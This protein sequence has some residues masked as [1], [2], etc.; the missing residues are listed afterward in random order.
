[1][2]A[3][4]VRVAI[5]QLHVE[6][7]AE[8][9]NLKKIC[10]FMRRA[11]S[12]GARL[13]VFSEAMSNGYVFHDIKE[14][15]AAA[16]TIPGPFID[17][18]CALASE[19]NMWVGLGLL[20]R[21]KQGIYN[22]A[23]LIS[24][25]GK[26][27]ATYRK[28]FFIRS[29]KIW[30]RHG[31]ISFKPVTTPFGSL[32][33]IICADMR[34][35]EPA[36]CTALSGAQVL[37]NL[38]NWG[39]PDQYE[40]HTPARAIENHFWIVSADKVGSEPGIHFP[41]HSQVVN[42]EGRVVAEASGVDEEL[43][44]VDIDPSEADRV[45]NQKRFSGRRPELY[46][47]LCEPLAIPAQDKGNS[48]GVMGRYVA[49]CQ[50][51]SSRVHEALAVCEEAY[52]LDEAELM[53]LP[54]LFTVTD[55]GDEN[56]IRQ[57]SIEASDVLQQFTDFSKATGTVL[58]IG[59]PMSITDGTGIANSAWVIDAGK[60]L[61]FYQKTHLSFDEAGKFTSGNNLPV[62]QTSVGTIGVLLGEE[63]YITEVPRLLALRGAEI[64]TWPCRWTTQ[65]PSDVL[66]LERAL[67]NQVYVVVANPAENGIGHSQVVS[68][69]SYPVS[70]HRV[71]IG[72]GRVGAVGQMIIPMTSHM[73][74]ISRNTDVFAHRKPEAYGILSA[75]I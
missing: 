68:P 73:K 35:P 45:S 9:R 26:I 7:W 15:E 53:V 65:R 19:L 67:E 33:L 24:A 39:G 32:G 71:A 51:V 60:V 34:I 48:A 46:Q 29:D 22:D 54:E 70:A 44:I 21:A 66:P 10:A 41:G 52:R 37:L 20:E 13:V 17:P 5:G 69:R 38:A 14:A 75:S 16:T 23:L 30:M 61:G 1:M 31:G 2:G 58:V 8:D 64:L 25:D 49:A 11:S 59:L 43:L 47:Q 28:T 42:P 63:G 62:F 55:I 74:L 40:I 3:N 50:V 57:R 72:P 4:H 12:F 27:Q 18:I 56:E 6:P 36:R